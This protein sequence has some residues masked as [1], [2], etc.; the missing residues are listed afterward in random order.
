MNEL[1]E[2]EPFTAGAVATQPEE[3]RVYARWLEWG[4]RLGFAGLLISFVLYVFGVLPAHVSP[5]DLPLLWTLPVDAFVAATQ[6]P[7]GW[8]WVALLPRAD[9]LGLAAIVLLSGCSLACLLAVAPIYWRRGDRM[10]AAL[11]VAVVLVVLLA[12]S[13]LLTGGH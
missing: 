8:G 11:A 3:H 13:G 10:H 4:T 9:A 1:P 5:Q 12:A 2:S 6:T 7:T